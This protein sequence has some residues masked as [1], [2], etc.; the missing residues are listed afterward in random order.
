MENESNTSSESVETTTADQSVETQ[1]VETQSTDQAETTSTESKVTE[2]MGIEKAEEGETSTESQPTIDDIVDEALRGE[3]SEETQKLIEDN[4]LGKHIDMLVE[5]N[6]A[7]QERNNQEVFSVVGGEDSYAELQEWGR[8]TMSKDQAQSFNDALFSGDMNLAKLAVQG[9]K[10]QYEAANG[11][12][13]DRVI[14]G[15]DSANADSQPFSD[16]KEYLSETKTTKYKR[17]PEFRA[18][19]EAKRNRSGF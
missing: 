3:L 14:S 18:Q 15:G 19:V 6:R 12:S 17:N 4:G 11:R 16:V 8:N 1:S 9:L 2:S 7:I 10:A 13:P 5:G